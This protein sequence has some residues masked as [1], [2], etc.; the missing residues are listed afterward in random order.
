MNKILFE[1]VRPEFES[2]LF[3][4]I[5]VSLLRKQALTDRLCQFQIKFR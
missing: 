2:V 1:P 5:G 3:F 4:L